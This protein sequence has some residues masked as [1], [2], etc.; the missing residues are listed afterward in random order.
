ADG[1]RV[2][3]VR[4]VEIGE[5]S[6]ILAQVA[7]R[8]DGVLP[9]VRVIRRR[10]GFHLVAT[11]DHG[12]RVAVDFGI[13]GNVTGLVDQ[14][15]IAS[16]R[17]SSGQYRRRAVLPSDRHIQVK[18]RIDEIP[19]HDPIVVEVLNEAGRYLYVTAQDFQLDW[20]TVF[21]GPWSGVTRVR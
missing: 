5:D 18:G 16:G 4:D 21:P 2:D 9:Q 8:E 17:S 14:V 3:L 1:G 13:S 7:D 20:L 10:R 6:P 11:P 15:G 12:H 19:D